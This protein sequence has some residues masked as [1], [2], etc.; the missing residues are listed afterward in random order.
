VCR[1]VIL[2]KFSPL[3][4]VVK[5][6][7]SLKCLIKN[8]PEIKQARLATKIKFLRFTDLLKEGLYLGTR[9][10]FSGCYAR[11]GARIEHRQR[12][13]TITF[14]FLCLFGFDSFASCLPA[15]YSL[16]FRLFQLPHPGYSTRS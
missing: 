13:Q 14:H 3:T 4:C 1:A 8:M 6:R 2:A 12:G 15:K 5:R 10:N 7:F 11:S 16:L 9:S